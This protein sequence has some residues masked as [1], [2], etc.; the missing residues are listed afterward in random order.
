LNCMKML[1]QVVSK[2]NELCVYGEC[3]VN[4]LWNSGGSHQ[5]IPIAQRRIDQICF[6][7]M[8]GAYSQNSDF[9]PENYFQHNNVPQNPPAFI[10]ASQP[11]SAVP[12]ECNY[13]VTPMPSCT[14]SEDSVYSF[15]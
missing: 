11:F 6:N 14:I 8:M 12:S 13:S 7:L 15:S 1:T 9:G 3:I 4:E 5:D 10:Y 2:Q